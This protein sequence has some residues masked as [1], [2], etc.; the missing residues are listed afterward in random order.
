MKTIAV[1]LLILAVLHLPAVAQSRVLAVNDVDESSVK[2]QSFALFKRLVGEKLGTRLNITISNGEALYDQKSL[3]QAEQLGAVQLAAPGIGIFTGTFPKLT[4]LALPY[5]LPSPQAIEDAVADPQIGGVLFDDMRKKGLEPLGIW[6]NGP[7][8]IGRTGDKPVLTPAD[9]K[10]LKIR[11]PP[12]DVY[13][14]TFR[15]LGSNVT[16]MSWGSVPTALQ[17]GVIDAVEPTP[18]AWVSSHL[19]EIA[20]QI[21]RTSYIWDFYIVTA[22]RAWWNGMPAATRSVL[23]DAMA[24]TTKWN[25]DNTGAENDRA[26]ETMRKSGAQIHD[27]THDEAL[28]WAAAVRPLWETIGNKTVGPDTMQRLVAIG[29]KYR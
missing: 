29:E 15:L 1:T 18:N 26:F 28:Q 9:M 4:V 12:G 7:R 17:Q 20:K 27:L 2:G 3:V 24:Q 6:L 14:D 10:G 21:T 22:N 16:T 25:W 8:D 23:T 13:V 5:L 19:Y 11:V